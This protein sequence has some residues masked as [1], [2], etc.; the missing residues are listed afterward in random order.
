MS[1]PCSIC[2]LFAKMLDKSVKLWFNK[3]YDM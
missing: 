3:I 2:T 1:P